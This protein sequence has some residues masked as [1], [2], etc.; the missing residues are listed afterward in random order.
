MQNKANSQR[1]EATL[2]IVPYKG[3]EEGRDLCRCGK[4]SQFAGLRLLRRCAPRNDIRARGG[5]SIRAFMTGSGWASVQ[6]KANSG[7]GEGTVTAVQ[8]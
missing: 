6:N 5:L 3:H 4:Q 7:K 8:E 1:Q 2:T